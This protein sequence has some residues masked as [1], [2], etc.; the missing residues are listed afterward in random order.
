MTFV[1]LKTCERDTGAAISA[2]TVSATAQLGAGRRD[3]SASPLRRFGAILSYVRLFVHWPWMCGSTKA[4]L[5]DCACGRIVR[6]KFTEQ[7]KNTL[8]GRRDT[9]VKTSDGA[10]PVR[11]SYNNG[12]NIARLLAAATSAELALV[13]QSPD[14]KKQPRNSNGMPV[15]V[16][17]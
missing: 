9:V 17:L 5:C 1:L 11:Q 12:D 10:S 16:W 15:A 8:Y 14:S 7:V 13:K 2:L 3:K 6:N 4:K